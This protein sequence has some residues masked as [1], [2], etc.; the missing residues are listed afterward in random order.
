M[1]KARKS[2]IEFRYYKMPSG[3]PIL[4]LLGREWI[5][6]YGVGIDYLHF[7]NCMEIGYC[8]SGSGILTVGEDDYQFSGNQFSVIPQNCPHCKCFLRNNPQFLK[9][10]MWG[11]GKKGLY[12]FWDVWYTIIK[13]HKMSAAAVQAAHGIG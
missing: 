3:I 6:T 11:N 13:F 4:A 5:R 8:Y 10:K 2:K 7:H 1:G 9:N 12:K